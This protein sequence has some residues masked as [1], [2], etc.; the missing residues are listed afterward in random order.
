[1]P[2]LCAVA[3]MKTNGDKEQMEEGWMATEINEQRWMV[4]RMIV[5][6]AKWCIRNEDEWKSLA[7]T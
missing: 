4:I 1:M 6:K 3:L 7:H 2:F 5:P